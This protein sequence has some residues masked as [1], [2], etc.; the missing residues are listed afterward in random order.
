MIGNLKWSRAMTRTSLG[1]KIRS[2]TLSSAGDVVHLCQW[3]ILN[4]WDYWFAF[5]YKLLSTGWSGEKIGINNQ[6]RAQ[7]LTGERKINLNLCLATEYSRN[8]QT[9]LM[10][11]IFGNQFL[12]KQ[13]QVSPRFIYLQN[14]F[15][16]KCIFCDWK[17][18]ICS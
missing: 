1:K 15:H 8:L 13:M 10:E 18:N 3:S 5:L 12:K 11:G 9:T 7:V 4:I 16:D 14:F 17:L 2:A 6:D